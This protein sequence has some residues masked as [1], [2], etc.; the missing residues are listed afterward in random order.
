MH[1]LLGKS[2]D[3]FYKSCSVFHPES[4][5]IGFAVFCFFQVLLEI[6]FTA[7]SLEL[8]KGLQVYPCYAD[9]SLERIGNSQLSPWASAGG[10]PA[11]IRRTGGRV[12]LGAGGGTACGSLGL[13]SQAWTGQDCSRRAQ[14]VAQG[15]AGR[16]GFKS[17]EGQAKSVSAGVVE[18]PRDARGGVGVLVGSGGGWSDGLSC[19]GAHGAVELRRGQRGAC[20]REGTRWP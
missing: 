19:G 10:S 8:F 9:G 17:G 3:K 1:K 13:D 20:T 2:I 5:K 15:G 6:H 16:C 4:N 14:T 7:R 11:K 12:Q 18:A